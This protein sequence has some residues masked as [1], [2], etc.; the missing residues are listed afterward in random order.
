[1]TLGSLGSAVMQVTLESNRLADGN[2]TALHGSQLV[3]HNFWYF[4]AVSERTKMDW[5][6]ISLGVL[7]AIGVANF[8]IVLTVLL[9]R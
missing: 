4:E 8:V 9:R 5:M 2:K 6:T 1:M 7:I 3:A